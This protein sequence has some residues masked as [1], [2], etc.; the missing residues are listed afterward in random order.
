M[1][2]L[3]AKLTSIHACIQAVDTVGYTGRQPEFL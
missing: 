3:Q 2:Y 1:P